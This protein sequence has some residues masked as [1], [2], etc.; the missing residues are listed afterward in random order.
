RQAHRRAVDPSRSVL[1]GAGTRMAPRGV[2]SH[3]CSERRVNS[4]IAMATQVESSAMQRTTSLRSLLGPLLAHDQ[5]R[6]RC[7]TRDLQ[8]DASERPFRGTF[9]PREPS[10]IKLARL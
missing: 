1:L 2:I 8:S 5:N 7:M 9:T 4:S 3:A 10:T 6:T